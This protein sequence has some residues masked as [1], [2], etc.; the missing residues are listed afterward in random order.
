M[1]N[2]YLEPPLP[3]KKESGK[4]E[5]EPKYFIFKRDKKKG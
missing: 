3:T 2:E 1:V 5:G 4:K